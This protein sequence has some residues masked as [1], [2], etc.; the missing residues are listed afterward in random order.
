[1]PAASRLADS[2]SCPRR[3]V[4]EISVTSKRGNNETSSSKNSDGNNLES[5][6]MGRIF[7]ASI[8]HMMTSPK[9]SRD[10]VASELT[11][12][13]ESRRRDPKNRS[14]REVGEPWDES[15]IKDEQVKDFKLSRMKWYHLEGS[16]KKWI[17][18]KHPWPTES[19]VWDRE[20][21]VNGEVRLFA[22]HKRISVWGKMDLYGKSPKRHYIVE[23][24]ETSTLSINKARAQASLYQ[25]ALSSKAGEEPVEGYVYHA[26][27]E[28]LDPLHDDE[29]EA[30][31]LK[32]NQQPPITHPQKYTCRNCPVRDCLERFS[33]GRTFS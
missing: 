15:W 31:F 16:F 14:L 26:T 32:G 3:F 19:T 27:K 22:D 25:K 12:W 1:M 11:K 30:I 33:D 7:E 9:Q 10:S 8:Q 20:E 6:A 13:L 24:K 23:L 5:I 2:T 18:A 21:P 29:W 28:I 17:R 4:F